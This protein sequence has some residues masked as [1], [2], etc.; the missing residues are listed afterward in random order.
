[1]RR[2]LS[3]TIAFVLSFLPGSVRSS[4]KLPA[5]LFRRYSSLLLAFAL[6]G[7]FHTVGHWAVIRARRGDGEA[8]AQLPA[9][10]EVPF[11]LAQ[12]AGIML[13]D[14]VCH[15][16]GVDDRRGISRSRALVGYMLTAAFYGWT[17]VQLKAMPI[18][19][20]LGIQDKRG[21]LFEVVE[22]LRVSLAAIPGNFVKMGMERWM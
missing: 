11:F 22:L 2:T 14:F 20:T 1:M 10:G 4:P 13:E 6:S 19:A 9:W 12:G 17:R 15:I 8:E 16:L 3:I 5:R 21:S 18:A 7:A